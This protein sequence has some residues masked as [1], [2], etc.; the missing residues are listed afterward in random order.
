VEKFEG[1][2]SL[3]KLT[4]RYAYH[5]KLDLKVIGLRGVDWINVAQDWVHVAGSCEHGN[6]LL[7]SIEC[8]EFLDYLTGVL[9]FQERLCT[10][11]LVRCV[12]K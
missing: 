1:N 3:G 12:I 7:G 10:M 8:G 9:A 11:E 4:R 6:E 2:R 5:I